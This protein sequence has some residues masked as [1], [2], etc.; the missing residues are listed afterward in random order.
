MKRLLLLIVVV[1]FFLSLSTVIIPAVPAQGKADVIRVSEHYADIT[2]DGKNDHISITGIKTGWNYYEK[3]LINI[4]G[5]N[6][7]HYKLTLGAGPEP[8]L[9]FV[10][11]THDGVKDLLACMK[12]PGTDKNYVKEA[13]TYK[14]SQV[15]KLK[16]PEPLIMESGFVN[17][18]KAILKVKNTGKIYV[19]D[20]KDRKKYYEKLGIF[21]KG[22][23]NEATE[24]MVGTDSQLKPVFFNGSKAGL[25]GIQTV[26]GAADT[27]KVSYVESLW[28][29]NDSEWQLTKVK[30]LKINHS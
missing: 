4:E 7:M 11:L 30:V 24:L 3:L 12:T 29:Y 23:L 1:P 16:L 17:G 9:M 28:S 5:S 19:L 18:Y 21:Y 25:K 8:S 10:D 13:F 15:T 22:K 14:S 20:L 2:G 6:K 26:T 27:D